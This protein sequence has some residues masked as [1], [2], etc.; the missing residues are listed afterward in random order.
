MPDL[1]ASRDRDRTMLNAGQ[2]DR[3]RRE[4]RVARA[5]EAA[6]RRGGRRFA[7][8]AAERRSVT[9]RRPARPSP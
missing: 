4:G 6:Q 8:S 1:P 7:R 5:L 9:Q 3:I 2:R